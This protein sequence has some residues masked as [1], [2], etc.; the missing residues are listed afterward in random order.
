[1][2][3]FAW[4]NLLT[5][6]LRTALALVGLSIPILGVLGLLSLST[7]LRGLVGDT[8]GRIQGLVVLKEN[9]FSPVLSDLNV[10]LGDTIR[11][12]PGVT[13]V[14][15]ELWRIPPAIEDRTMVGTVAKAGLGSMLG[16]GSREAQRQQ[17][18]NILDQPVICGQKIATHQG[19][20]SAIFPRALKEG[21][22]LRPGDEGTNRIVISKKT[23]RDFP[24]PK[25]DAPRKL[26]DTIEIGKE[27]CEILGLYETGT[28]ILDTVI[29][30]DIETARRINNIPPDLVSTFY[31]ES[32]DPANIDALSALIEQTIPGV[33]ARS[34]NEIMTEFG[35]L[36]NQLDLFLLATVMLALVVGVVGIVNTMLMS[37]TERFAEFGVLRTNG[38]SRGNVL[39]LVSIE[40]AYLGLLAGAIGFT[41]A[42]LFTTVANTFLAR[43]GLSLSLTP[44]D[45]LKGLALSVVMGLL[46]G[47]Y[48]AWKASRLV[49]MAAIR[50]GAH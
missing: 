19:L 8:L 26:G 24:D 22:F 20:K 17:M 9:A 5:R 49:P 18:Q 27:P 35:S 16:G 12:L 7:G 41:L 25:T 42:L 38:W 21:R 30:M 40:S 10:G 31:V 6:P 14:A 4:R 15:E 47:L 39:S 2:W 44:A 33:D 37:T 1:M 45:A 11:K 28:I 48:P 32:D 34:P 46:G 13:A 43:S 50:L 29:V 23:A 3:T 36:M